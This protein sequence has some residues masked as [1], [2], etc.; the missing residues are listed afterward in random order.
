MADPITILC[1]DDDADMLFIA[2]LS[3]ELDQGVAV[4][5]ARGGE[6]ALRLL[7]ATARRF[8]CILLDMQM[9]TTGGAELL[10]LI[11]ARPDYAAVPIIFLTASVRSHD[12][13]AHRALGA[14]GTIAKPFDPLTLAA[15]VRTLTN[16][17]R[18]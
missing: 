5:T 9:P 2:R 13:E 7:D 18:A 6:A 16:A 11:R 15:Q 14:C 3:L 4:T 1:I 12:R 17:A 8:D 10:P